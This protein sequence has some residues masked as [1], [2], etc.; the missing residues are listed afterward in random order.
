MRSA[1]YGHVY[2]LGVALDADAGLQR[3]LDVVV[4]FDL[5]PVWAL[6]WKTLRESN[7][8]ESTS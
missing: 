3:L 8:W 7:R 6:M 5:L 2:P 4:L 1:A